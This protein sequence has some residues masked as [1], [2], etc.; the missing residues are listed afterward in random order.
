[1]DNVELIK[2]IVLLLDTMTKLNKM[3]EYQRKLF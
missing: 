1:M 3:K 2:E